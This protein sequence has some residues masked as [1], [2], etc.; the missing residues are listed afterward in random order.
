MNGVTVLVVVVGR[1]KYQEYLL[2]CQTFSCHTETILSIKILLAH[3][4]YLVVIIPL[5]SHHIIA[6]VT[7]N[8]RKFCFC[9]TRRNA[10]LSQVFYRIVL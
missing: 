2:F 6:S 7:I 8:N 9:M 10:T 1:T 4:I 5:S 3:S